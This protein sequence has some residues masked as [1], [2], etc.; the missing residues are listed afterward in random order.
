MVQQNIA[1]Q[2]KKVAAKENKI[3]GTQITFLK[4]KHNFLIKRNS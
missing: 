1:S 2:G 4:L 3:K